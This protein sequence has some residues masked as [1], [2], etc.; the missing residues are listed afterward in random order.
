MS[1]A[2][3]LGPGASYT[4]S[5]HL[6]RLIRPNLRRVLMIG[7]GGGTMAKQVTHYYGDTTIDVV[8]VDPL[9]VDLSK[10]F[11]GV[12]EN[13]RLRIH[14]ADGRTFL[15]RS[16]EKWDLIIID[17]YT[18]NRYGHT[19]P[20]H[21][22]TQEFFREA[23]KHLNDGGILHFHCAFSRS[24]LFPALENTISGVFRS[25]LATEGEIV[26]SDVPLLTA[27]DVIAERSRQTQTVRLPNLPRY[28]A[29]LQPVPAFSRDVVLLRDDYAPVDTMLQQR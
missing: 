15:S 25:T 11:F 16:S 28:I 18:T 23:Q 20:P 5:F 22:V 26:A 24:K 7:L 1:V 10:R 3:P 14:V 9:I 2:D 19:I 21:L 4:D 17:A 8:E 27:S 12:Q 29:E 6:G 13:D